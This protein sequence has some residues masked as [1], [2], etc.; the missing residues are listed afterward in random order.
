MALREEIF[1]F[2]NRDAQASAPSKSRC[3]GCNM[4]FLFVSLCFLRQLALSPA[5][6]ETMLEA[7]IV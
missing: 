4:N 6:A 1:Q 7:A 2:E 3:F 5:L